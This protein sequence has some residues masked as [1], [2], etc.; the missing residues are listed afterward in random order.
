MM[1]FTFLFRGA[2]RQA[3]FTNTVVNGYHIRMANWAFINLGLD[4][5]AFVGARQLC[6]VHNK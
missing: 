2:G 5:S 6:R 3:G 1:A 4:V